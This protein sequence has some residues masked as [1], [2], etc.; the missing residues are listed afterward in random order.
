MPPVFLRDRANRIVQ[1]GIEN[2]ERLSQ[3]IPE[4]MPQGTWIDIPDAASPASSR[5]NC[6]LRIIR[7]IALTL[8]GFISSSDA[9]SPARV[10]AKSLQH[11]KNF[12]KMPDEA[13]DLQN[14]LR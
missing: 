5:L 14:E 10:S 2:T 4:I 13:L 12:E 3:R 1:S 11:L 7:A 9:G 8:H 6:S